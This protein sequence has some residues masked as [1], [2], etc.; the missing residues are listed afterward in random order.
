[1]LLGKAFAA[2][3]FDHL[4]VGKHMVAQVV[5]PLEMQKEQF[6][7]FQDMLL[8]GQGMMLVQ[9][10]AQELVLKEFDLILKEIQAAQ[11]LQVILMQLVQTGH[12][13]FLC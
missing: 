10:Q 11:P 3:L 7:V 8:V 5:D 4:L 9:D 6:A 12:A 1:V 13:L 2:L